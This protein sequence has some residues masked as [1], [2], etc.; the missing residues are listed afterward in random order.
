MLLLS[1]S[2]SKTV[3]V[4][5]CCLGPLLSAAPIVPWSDPNCNDP[6][7]LSV[8]IGD[9][10]LDGNPDLAVRDA[11]SNDVTILRGNGTGGFS[12]SST[13]P[14]ALANH[15]LPTLM[16]DGAG[17]FSPSPLSMTVG[18]FNGDGEQDIAVADPVSATVTILLGDGAGGFFLA[19]GSPFPV[20]ALP[21][22]VT[23]AGLN[24][25]SHQNQV[26]ASADSDSVS[27]LLPTS[28]SFTICHDH[29]TT[30]TFPANSSELQR[31]LD[32]GDTV[33]ACTPVPVPVARR[34]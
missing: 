13:S 24:R 34:Y 7:S 11:Y 12:T 4:L 17:S 33:G 9:F 16:G 25:D 19:G 28:A 23:V 14:V 1:R 27:T 5:A 6:G 2:F 26:I 29:A 32:H 20:N 31:H 21:A 15:H 30:I 22:D 10:D 18:D 3:L 8:V